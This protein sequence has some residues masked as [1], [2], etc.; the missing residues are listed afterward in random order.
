MTPLI[1]EGARE[2]HS[3]VSPKLSDNDNK[4]YTYFYYT[5]LAN[6]AVVSSARFK[7]FTT[8]A[9]FLIFVLTIDNVV[10]MIR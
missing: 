9:I 10:Y 5:S 6:T 7:S 4:I 3:L 8:A 1:N 2:E